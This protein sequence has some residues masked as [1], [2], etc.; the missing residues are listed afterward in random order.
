MDLD[1][2]PLTPTAGDQS[3]GTIIPPA[4][5]DAYWLTPY[6]T[7]GTGS[8]NTTYIVGH[9][10]ENRDS[11]FNR[12]SSQ[13]KPG[14]LFTVTTTTGEVTYTVNSVTTHN[15][16]TLN[17]SDIWDIVP[18]RLILVSCYTADLWGKNVVV[19]AS[20]LG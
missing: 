12:A 7:P 9:S 20:P 6:G 3:S 10:W 2:L 17:T 1:I 18:G 16:D 13:A 19:T 5:L 8:V 14:D 11:A 15:K 4:T